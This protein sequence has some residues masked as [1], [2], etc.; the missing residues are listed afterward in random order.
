M[1]KIAIPSLLLLTALY[2]GLANADAPKP[3]KSS[4]AQ[5]NGAI[6]QQANA[7][8]EGSGTSSTIDVV[9]YDSKDK[10]FQTGMFKSGPMKVELKAPGLDHDEFLHFISGGITL[11]SSDGTRMEVGAGESVTL[12]KGWTGTFETAG[13]S[14]IYVIYNAPAAKP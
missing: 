3:I 12:P 1:Q 8:K 11:T 6:Y 2:N 9:T 4:A 13:Y 5:V 10:A 7:V 14:K